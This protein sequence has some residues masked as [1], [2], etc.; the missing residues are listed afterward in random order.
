VGLT[1]WPPS[2]A[3]CLEILGVWTSWSL[4]GLFRPVQ[5]WLMACCSTQRGWVVLVKWALS[6]LFGTAYLCFSFGRGT[7]YKI[8]NSWSLVSAATLWDAVQKSDMYGF[9]GHF[10]SFVNLNAW[11]NYVKTLLVPPAHLN[12]DFCNSIRLKWM[13]RR[14]DFRPPCPLLVITITIDYSQTH[15]ASTPQHCSSKGAAPKILVLNDAN[16]FQKHAKR[17]YFCVHYPK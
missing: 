5:R 8:L 6:V 4:R 15:T 9:L 13:T 1:T 3:D 17:S 2:F 14:V 11:M 12:A 7:Y 10:A 16:P